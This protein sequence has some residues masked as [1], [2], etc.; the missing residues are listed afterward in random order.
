[1]DIALKLSPSCTE[2]LSLP[3]RGSLQQGI[4]VSQL[5]AQGTKI[6]IIDQGGFGIVELW[7]WGDDAVVLKRQRGGL[8]DTAYIQQCFQEE[9]HMLRRVSHPNIVKLITPVFFNSSSG[10]V[11][12][13]LLEFILGQV[14]SARVMDRK[15]SFK[16]RFNY[17]V[18][19]A[20]TL[21]FLHDFASTGGIVHR[22]VKPQNF[23][24]EES[25][26]KE[27]RVVLVDFGLAREIT[28]STGVSASH[29][30]AGTRDFLSPEQ[31]NGGS[32]TCKVDVYAFGI[33]VPQILTGI[34]WVLNPTQKGAPTNEYFPMKRMEETMSLKPTSERTNV[35]EKIRNLC[36]GC[37]R[38]NPEDRSEFEDIVIV[39][40]SVQTSL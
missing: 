37:V 24:V 20:E 19:I 16:T 4:T 39:L 14:L 30:G 40:R 36:M 26:G 12:G 7:K 8:F 35:L 17:V 25:D 3:P 11:Q 6:R 33:M 27:E 10:A 29:P 38:V 31:L 32:V 21:R 23:I 13:L 2:L 9:L 28:S 22:D 5:T 18:Q 1:L 34:P 15:L